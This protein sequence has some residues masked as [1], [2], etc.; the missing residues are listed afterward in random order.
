MTIPGT[1][2]RLDSDKRVRF[3]LALF[4][5]AAKARKPVLAIC[6]GAQLV[7][8]ALGGSLY[9]DIKRQVPKSMRHGTEKK[10]GKVFHSVDIFEG[11]NLC[12]IMGNCADGNCSLRVRS[13]HHQSIKNP[14][15]GLRLAAVSPDGVYEALEG[16]GSAFLIATQWHPEKM[17]ADKA[18]RKL[19]TALVNA[20][21]K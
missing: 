16:R 10:G 4:R 11:T 8:V 17:P 14:G 6:Y 1:R 7:N 15:R 2:L 18:T 9:Q 20:S 19:F 21:R 5:T 12:A 13:A 3:E